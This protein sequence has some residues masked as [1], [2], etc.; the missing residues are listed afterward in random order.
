MTD[1]ENLSHRFEEDPDWSVD[2]DVDLLWHG[3]SSNLADS[4]LQEGLR[5]GSHWGSLEV[6]EY[7]AERNCAEHGGRPVLIRLPVSA[8]SREDFMVDEQMVD[9][10]VFDDYDVRAMAYEEVEAEGEPTWEDCLRVYESVVY[11]H[12]VTVDRSDIMLA[13]GAPLPEASPAPSR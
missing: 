8:F 5:P 13:S 7:F 10:P 9:F 2:R 6:A 4:I 3:T 12:K 11:P 1:P